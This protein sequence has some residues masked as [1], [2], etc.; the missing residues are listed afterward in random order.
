MNKRKSI[1][2]AFSWLEWDLL[3]SSL[4]EHKLRQ[5]GIPLISLTSLRCESSTITKHDSI[6]SDRV[7]VEW[8]D[9]V[10]K[11]WNHE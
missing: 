9:N 11:K 4:I 7:I 2:V 3:S 10:E 5:A 6:W 8:N 1:S